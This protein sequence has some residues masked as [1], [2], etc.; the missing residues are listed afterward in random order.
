ML[1]ANRSSDGL[2]YPIFYGMAVSVHRN[3]HGS[4]RGA[5]PIF[6]IVTRKDVVVSGF[7]ELAYGLAFHHARTV[8]LEDCHFVVRP[9]GY[10]ALV[11]SGIR[12]VHAFVVGKLISWDS[13]LPE[14]DEVLTYD[15]FVGPH[16]TVANAPVK[17]AKQV[18]IGGK[19]YDGRWRADMRMTA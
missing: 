5:E 6:S 18:T 2:P 16:F 15:P 4:P 7:A 3:L 1:A 12:N 19:E 8:L 14:L 17:L 10:E 9:A 11:R 13:D